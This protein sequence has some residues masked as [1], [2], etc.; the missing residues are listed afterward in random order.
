MGNQPGKAEDVEAVTVSSIRRSGIPSPRELAVPVSREK[1]PLQRPISIKKGPSSPTSSVTPTPTKSV[2]PLMKLKPENEP[3][4]KVVLES[5]VKELLAEAK[6]KELEIS[7]LRTELKKCKNQGR[8][9]P[10]PAAI[11]E[12]PLSA[13]VPHSEQKESPIKVLREQNS[14]YQQELIH[15]REENR[16]LKMKLTALEHSLGSEMSSLNSPSSPSIQDSSLGSPI[17]PRNKNKDKNIVAM[18]GDL[19]HSPGSTSSD[20]TKASSSADCSEFENIKGL[21][22]E[23]SSNSNASPGGLTS[24]EGPQNGKLSLACLTEKIHKMEENQHSTAEELQA[25][26]QE[27]TDQQQ[28]VLELTA[29]NE[30]LAEHKNLLQTSLHQQRERVDQLTQENK[31]LMLLLQ[32]RIKNEEENSKGSRTLELEQKCSE[33]VENSRF[34]REKLLSIQQHLS[35]SLRN[36]EKEHHETQGM[37]K[38]LKE[39][40]SHLQRLLDSQHEAN[41]VTAIRLKE[42]EVALN[43]LKAENERL[44]TQLET[45]KEKVAELRAI[46]CV[47]GNSELEERL[48]AAHIEKESLNSSCAD[49]REE[50][51]QANSDIEQLQSLLSKVEAECHR[52]KNVCDKQTEELNRVNQQLQDRNSENEVEIKAMKETIFELEDQVEQQ[53]AV[54]LHRNVTISD[55]QNQVQALEE[56]KLELEKRL[57]TLSKQ[58]K[59][60]TEEWKRFQ[61]DLQTAVVVAN[62]I[63]C[64]AQQE[65]R[66][67]KRKLQEE[68]ERN[69]KLQKELQQLQSERLGHQ[70][71]DSTDGE[72]K[73]GWQRTSLSRTVSVPLEPSATV[74]SL[75]KSFDTAVAGQSI[76]IHSVPRSPLSGIPVRTAPAAAVSPMQRHSS[77]GHAKSI[78]RVTET[79]NNLLDLT[80]TDVVKG[81]SEDLKPEMFLRKSPSLE[82]VV[83]TPSIVLGTQISSSTLPNPKP[84]SRLS[85]E[86]KDPLAALA[87]EYGGSKRNA[88]LK[89]C[90]KKTEGYQNIDITNFS[91]SWGD[92][93][94]LCALLHTYL[95]A[96]IPY[97]E[98]STQDKKRNITLAFQA[99]ESV[100]INT[101]LDV[102]DM[103]STDRPDW[104]SMMQYV[105]QIYKY[106]E[107]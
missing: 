80:F 14:T 94:A 48:K 9:S 106:F 52:L 96:H 66:A 65:L 62:D 13:L 33:L 68:E 81:R 64:E 4:E 46:Q 38:S 21:S 76:P 88:L 79:R 34:E 41:N 103:L 10:D 25:T 44:S 93:L 90:Q 3:S 92:G 78:S 50:L 104:Q 69:A 102:N 84:S 28:V 36:L 63:K 61:A 70:Q 97:Q 26:I 57:K 71:A 77:S 53:R 8:N 6:T 24:R 60:D 89:W 1:V 43:E 74:K 101:A 22:R 67:A 98:L 20:V 45:E 27:L 95:P 72:L 54:Q 82:S 107:T 83:K 91:S 11:I 87:R 18:N 23:D 29:E 100:G 42:F 12:Q 105:A 5:H 35:S 51:V 17:K 47:S 2:R 86:R 99:A 7:R 85:V 59:E 55:L 56:E 39:E 49:L 31:N 75:I 15:L 40:N 32:E 16:L 73:S 30:K 19:V 37:L 58:L